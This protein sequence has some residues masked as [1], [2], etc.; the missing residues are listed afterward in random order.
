MFDLITSAKSVFFLFGVKAAA[1]KPS[2]G[3]H[4]VGST[5][6]EGW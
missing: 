3:T 2:F 1:Q 6:S 5:F 4:L